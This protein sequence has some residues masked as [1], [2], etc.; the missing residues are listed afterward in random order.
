MIDF[1]EAREWMVVR[2]IVARGVRDANVLSAMRHVPR[3]EFVLVQLREFAYDDRA[4]PIASQQT[5]SQ[6]AIV[7][8]M[9]EAAE[10]GPRDRVLDVGTGSGYA[11]AIAAEIVAH[12]HSV[13]RDPVLA[14]TARETLARLGISNVTVHLCDGTVG[15][16]AYAPYDAI[17]AGA[18]GPR[19]PRAWREQLSI[20]GRIVMPVGHDHHHQRLIKLV[21]HGEHD[22]R[23]RWLGDVSFVPLIGEDGWDACY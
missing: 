22:Y 21:R 7:A 18:G 16:S 1:R 2:Q 11:A 13:E 5:I 6:P 23:E 19:V 15:L 20:G 3:E 17:I 14:E 8:Q 4:L 10:L 9:M 12:V